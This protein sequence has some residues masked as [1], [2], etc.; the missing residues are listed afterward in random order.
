MGSK[1]LTLIVQTLIV[2]EA[3]QHIISYSN[4][5]YAMMLD[6]TEYTLHRRA[7]VLYIF[8]RKLH[9]ESRHL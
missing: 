9:K 1:S 5:P 7:K 2:F 4:S 3:K 8:N 6:G